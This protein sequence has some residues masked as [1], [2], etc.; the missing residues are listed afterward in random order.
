MRQPREF[1]IGYFGRAPIIVHW[2][3]L[4]ALPVSWLITKN[5]VGGLAGFFAY[6]A[7]VLVH[8]LGHAVVARRFR[9]PVHA[10]KIYWLHGLCLYEAPG[11]IELE[12]R[13]AWGGVIAQM[14][15]FAAVAF[16]STTAG[17]MN[18]TLPAVLS[19][20]FFIWM[21]VNVVVACNN[22]LPVKPLDGALAWQLLPILFKQK[23]RQSKRRKAVVKSSSSEADAKKIVSL[24]L[25]RIA[26]RKNTD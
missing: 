21:P 11:S 10:I 9:V 23:N 20:I 5:F 17:L 6:F 16:F 15:L 8:E 2:S 18:L 3:V 13:I 1:V 14:L 12:S 7:L 19:P 4:L 26:R 24:A 22:L 25:E